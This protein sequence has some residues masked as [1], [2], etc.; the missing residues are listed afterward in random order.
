[1][2]KPK[3]K[4]QFNHLLNIR[5][6]SRH[7]PIKDFIDDSDKYIRLG[8]G[9]YF[10]IEPEEANEL[11]REYRKEKEDEL[12]S[13]EEKQQQIIR[14]KD[15]EKNKVEKERDAFKTESTEKAQENEI[16]RKKIEE[17]ENTLQKSTHPSGPPESQ[18]NGQ[19]EMLIPEGAT[20]KELKAI[21]TTGW[22]PQKKGEMTRAINKLK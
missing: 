10:D 19:S 4:P 21:D 11:A 22:T 12:R 8:Y 15:E 7:V 6:D 16:L 5:V 3:L 20:L 18:E 14:E 17:L 2:A 13:S 1:M 9:H